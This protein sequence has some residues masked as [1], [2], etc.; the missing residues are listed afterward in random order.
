MRNNVLIQDLNYA[1][2]MTI[3]SESMDALDEVLQLMNDICSLGVDLSII[4]Q[5]NTHTQAL[6]QLKHTDVLHI[7]QDICLYIYFFLK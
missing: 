2:D 1:D 5:A 4:I 6:N 7:H 3:V